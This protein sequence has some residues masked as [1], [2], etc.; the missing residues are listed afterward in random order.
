MTVSWLEVKQMAQELRDRNPDANLVYG[1]PMGGIP[2]AAL[3]GLPLALPEGTGPITPETIAEQFDTSSILVVDDLID[4]GRTLAPF[5]AAGFPCDSLFRKPHSPAGLCQMAKEVDKWVIFPWESAAGPEDSVVRL[6]EWIGEDP[7]REGLRD[8]PRRVVKAFREMTAGLYKT[9]AEVLG[10][11]FSETSDQMVVVR[12]IRFSSLCE[13]HLLPFSGTATVGYIPSG[14]VVG[15]SKIPRMV[16]IFAK[17]PQVQ[18]RLTNQIAA[19]MMEYLNP[20]G[21]GV[22]ISARHSCMGCRGAVQPD[23][24]MVTSAMLGC[25]RDNAAARAELLGFI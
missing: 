22:V 8:T 24:E 21:V 10:T 16:E 2:V 20:A 18:E 3:T 7:K 1:V 6:L 11:T 17:R 12:G 5:E 23:A 13:H 9:P 19:A 25:V 14:R 4:S 15:L